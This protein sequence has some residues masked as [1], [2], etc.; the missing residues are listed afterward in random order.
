MNVQPN[1]TH[2]TNLICIRIRHTTH[3]SRVLYSPSKT[4]SYRRKH[5][6]RKHDCRDKSRAELSLEN[7][8]RK[9]LFVPFGIKHVVHRFPSRGI[10]M[11]R[12]ERIVSAP[13]V[14]FS[15]LL[16]PV[17][18]FAAEPLGREAPNRPLVSVIVPCY[19]GEAYLEDAL[20][21]ALEQSYPR[22]EVVVIDDG[23]TDR[24]AELAQSFPVRYIRQENR[25]LSH[26]RNAGI[27][28]SRGDYV[29]FL[30]ADDRLKPNA[31]EAGLQALLQRPDCAMAIGDHT[32]IAADGSFLR[33]S[34][35][36][37]P[38]HSHY[39]A[40]LRSN[41][42]EMIS[43][44]LFRRCVFEEVGGFDPDL[45]V[46]EDYE[47]YLRI[48]R[49]H[50]VCCHPAVVAEYRKH[51]RNTSRDSERMLT[52]TLRVLQDQEKYLGDDPGR[53]RAFREGLRAWRKQYGRQLARE[54]A[55][56]FFR[57]DR[58]PRQRKLRLLA[59]HYPL[60]LLLAPL[61]RVFP[62]L[63]SVEQFWFSQPLGSLAANRFDAFAFFGGRAKSPCVTR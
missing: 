63:G 56:S 31:I 23:S 45:G 43:S 58:D 29:I 35:K 39:R 27:Q 59:T 61:L 15:A 49:Q 11:D 46:S 34:R 13:P 9:L 12:A 5:D 53:R 28:Q 52:T 3:N 32:F 1:W 38:V 14:T 18:E 24:S 48:A 51:R 20:W 54:L 2:E 60:G 26:A 41:F 7:V 50:P 4:Y 25:G 17:E 40:L 21:S 19:N 44:V 10:G 55:H 22:V 33:R 16:E 30:D 8:K 37:H 47:L 62:S 36:I 6:C 57:L 42:I